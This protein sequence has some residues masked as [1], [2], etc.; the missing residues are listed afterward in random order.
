MPLIDFWKATPDVVMNMTIEQITLY[1]GDG[2]L[3]ANSECQKELREF[4]F[5]G[6]N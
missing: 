1:A 4:L 6:I 2:K 3:L 5:R